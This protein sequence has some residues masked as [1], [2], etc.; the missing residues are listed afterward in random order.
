MHLRNPLPPSTL[1]GIPD[2]KAGVASTLDLMVKLVKQGKTN[3]IIRQKATE[4]TQELRQKDF[5]GEIR[6]LFDF[7]QNNIR[8]VRD[9]AG[10]ETLHY[11]EQILLQEHG[12]CDDKAILLA[13]LLA[14]IGHPTRFVAVG[15]KPGHFSHV[16]VDT[17]YGPGWL[18]LD[19]T[20]PHP[21]GWR[22]PN[23]Q[24]VMIRN[25]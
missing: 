9:I 16:F 21:M 3:P 17:R 14:A 23:I 15:F 7:V 25:N 2:G 6:S 20:E 8:Y 24:S 12:D 13:S 19:A 22:P 18:T 10:V 5:T 4:L 1:M 11:P